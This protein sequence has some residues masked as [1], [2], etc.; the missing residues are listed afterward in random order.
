VH[1]RADLVARLQRHQNELKVVPG[2]EH[3]AEILVLDRPLLDIV[4]IALHVAFLLGW[5][6][7][8]STLRRPF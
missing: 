8:C 2:V 6:S 3:T 4:T 5:P 7:A 1:L